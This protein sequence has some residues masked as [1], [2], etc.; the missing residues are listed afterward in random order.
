VFGQQVNAEADLEISFVDTPIF[1]GQVPSFGPP[2][3]L[4]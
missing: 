3:G 2:A 1:T 4:K